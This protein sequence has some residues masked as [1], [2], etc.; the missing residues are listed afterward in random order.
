MTGCGDNFGFGM[1][2]VSAF[3]M[4]AAIVFT[5]SVG[6]NDPI[7]HGVT[8]CGNYIIGIGVATYTGVG[9]VAICLA[10][11][12]CDYSIILVSCCGNF[13]EGGVVANRAVLICVVTG[14]DAGGFLSLDLSQGVAGCIHIV[15]L[16]GVAAGAGVG[17]V[18]VHSTSGSCH[19]SVILVT[20]SCDLLGV[21]IAAGAGEGL[22][23]LLGAGGLLGHDAIVVAVAGC[24]ALGL[25]ADGT[26]LGSGAGCICPVVT[27]SCLQLG[28]TN[29]TSLR[30]L[31][32]GLCAGLVTL[33]F[34]LG[35][36]AAVGA[37]MISVVAVGQ[38]FDSLL[39]NGNSAAGRTFLT[40]GQTG[41]SAVG[42]LAGDGYLGV[43]NSGNITGFSALADRTSA[44]LNTL[45]RAGRCLR[46]RPS[47]PR[48]TDSCNSISVFGMPTAGT[49]VD[50]IACCGTSGGNGLALDHIVASGS[51]IINSAA[52]SDNVAICGTSSRNIL[53]LSNIPPVSTI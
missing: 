40:I 15:V 11:G 7:A 27:K 18:T 6:I 14:L 25:A 50:S 45:Y 38:H 2:A 8:G 16:V 46:L 30:I 10:S 52:V 19:N 33:V 37:D 42:G 12:G 29:G 48:V 28:T 17:G 51:L 3:F 44:G 43:C 39:G 5:I 13:L 4:L 49:G 20:L 21:A 32:I 53:G 41:G 1:I 22:N 34:A 9:G 47:A 35:L 36:A 31:T 24:L 23:A 26:G